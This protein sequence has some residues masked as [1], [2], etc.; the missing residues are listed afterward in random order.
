MLTFKKY[1]E[2]KAMN[3]RVFL[4][5]ESRLGDIAKVGFEFEMAFDETS[6]LTSFGGDRYHVIDYLNNYDNPDEIGGW[7]DITRK[8][9]DRMDRDFTSWVVD[10]RNEYVEDNYEKFVDDDEDTPVDTDEARDLA[11][12]EFDSEH[13]F[14]MSDYI[15][16]EYGTL[17]SMLR[18]YYCGPTYGWADEDDG[19]FYTEDD[20]SIFEKLS[21]ATKESLRDYLNITNIQINGSPTL[22][23]NVFVI[24]QDGSIQGGEGLELVTPPV[25]LTESLETANDICG[26][27]KEHH[28]KTNSTTGLH[29]NVSLPGIKDNLDPLKLI[30]FMGEDFAL[31]QFGRENNTYASKHLPELIEFIK[32]GKFLP[33][34]ENELMS[35]SWQFLKTDKYMSVNLG[36]LRLGYLEFR[37]AGGENYHKNFK[38]I[39]KTVLRFVAAV[40]LAC[41]PKSERQEYIKKLYKLFNSSESLPQSED[42]PD[43]VPK[44]LMRIFD[45]NPRHLKTSF[46]VYI[47]N[48]DREY[49][50]K[51]LIDVMITSIQILDRMRKTL[52]PKERAYFKLEAK[53]IGLT[54]SDI[55]KFF[56]GEIKNR[57]LF[58]KAT[59]L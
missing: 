12:K 36:K 47:N 21:E 11:E 37:V 52:D 20:D 58:R 32:K 6:E 29:I 9:L 27:M 55:D 17:Q 51:A 10:K 57:E 56:D 35:K 5:V 49:A 30:L 34:T 2:E 54:T 26:W 19:A 41:D 28:A 46:G 22:D 16:D 23:N 50:K 3:D 45:I 53:R 4:D 25:S 24:T 42:A 14:S 59:G 43:W 8:D 38:L 15:E 48:N 40:E 1:I 18:H 33:K 31:S 7:F 39:R 13:S 44:E